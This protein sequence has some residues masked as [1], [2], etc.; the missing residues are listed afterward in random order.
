MKHKIMMRP[1]E[2][3]FSLDWYR[4]DKGAAFNELLK[5]KFSLSKLQY[6][7]KYLFC[8]FWFIRYKINAAIKA[9]AFNSIN[10]L[11]NNSTSGTT[12]CGVFITEIRSSSQV[13]LL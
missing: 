13:Q 4:D 6:K 1:D 2:F 10:S 12:E 3:A 9:T 5:L 8:R 11:Y 7:N